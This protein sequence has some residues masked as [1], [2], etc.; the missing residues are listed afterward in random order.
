MIG[1][2]EGTIYTCV[3]KIVTDKF[4][5]NSSFCRLDVLLTGFIQTFQHICL[6]NLQKTKNEQNPIREQFMKAITPA[7]NR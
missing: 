7:L 5:C 1:I 3:K 2:K 4:D 6:L